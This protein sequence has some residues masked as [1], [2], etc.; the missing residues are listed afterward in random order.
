MWLCS[1]SDQREGGGYN[2]PVAEPATLKSISDQR[3]G[4]GYN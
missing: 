2:T 3:E 4:G 1:I